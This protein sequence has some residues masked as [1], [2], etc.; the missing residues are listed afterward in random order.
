MLK[1]RVCIKEETCFPGRTVVMSLV[2]KD[3]M[4]S[5][6]V[7]TLDSAHLLHRNI[8]LKCGRKI[9]VFEGGRIIL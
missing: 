2:G 9:R 7:R 3:K 6:I 1:L 4:C 5:H 8:I